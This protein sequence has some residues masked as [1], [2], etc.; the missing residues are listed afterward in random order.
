MVKLLKLI[1]VLVVV[2]LCEFEKCFCEV[3]YSLVFFFDCIIYYI[4]CC[5][6][7]QVWFMFIFFMVQFCGGIQD[8]IYMVV[9][10]VELL[11]IVFLVYDDVVDDVNE[12]WSF[13]FINVFWKN[14]V[15]VLVGDFL[16]IRGLV[17]VL[18][19]KQYYFLQIVFDVFEVII[20]GEFLQLEKVCC[21]DI[22]EQ[23]YY[24]VI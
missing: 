8:V 2:E 9:L 14:K 15:V 24:D 11:Y 5:K 22:D 10:L 12:R 19:D 7:K 17:L 20:E 4:V 18:C 3:M 16:L 23:V 1:Q 21:F 13:F 6:G